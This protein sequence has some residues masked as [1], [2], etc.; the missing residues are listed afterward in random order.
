M[1]D[2]NCRLFVQVHEIFSFDFWFPGFVWFYFL[3]YFGCGLV[4]SLFNYWLLLMDNLVQIFVRIVYDAIKGNWKPKSRKKKTIRLFKIWIRFWFLFLL[5]IYFGL[6]YLKC[7]THKCNKYT[8]KHTHRD[9]YT[10]KKNILTHTRTHKHRHS[11]V[12]VLRWCALS[13]DNSGCSSSIW[14]RCS[15]GSSIWFAW[16]SW[17]DTGAVVCSS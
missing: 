15:W 1:A 14:P 4:Y 6:L 3:V 11:A 8:Q 16:C 9:K 12:L 10:Y 13:S 2:L 5:G 17:S 7:V